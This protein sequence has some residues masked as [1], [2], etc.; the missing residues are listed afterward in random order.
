[1]IDGSETVSDVEF[2]SSVDFVCNLTSK[3]ALSSDRTRVGLSVY[4]EANEILCSFQN[5]TDLENFR[6]T[7]ESAITKKSRTTLF[8]PE[9]SD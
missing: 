5:N 9:V 2:N 6:L 7:A 4:S 3:F 1:M 8:I